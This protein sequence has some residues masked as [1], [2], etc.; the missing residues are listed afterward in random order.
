MSGRFEKSG[1]GTRENNMKPK[2]ISF[3]NIFIG[4]SAFFERTLS[5][6]DVRTFAL[7]SGDMNPLHLDE[8]YA[9]TTK[10]K[11]R[12]V[13]GMLL[14]SLCSALVGTYL[15]GKRCLYLRQTLS[16][17]KPVFVGDTVIIHGTVKTKSMSTKIV[18]I[19]ISITKNGEEVVEGMATVQMI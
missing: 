10:F 17:K 1:G 14:G 9:K 13:Y 16:F 2:D 7:L 11:R 5:D 3:E 6:E 8:E 18:E 19:L 4:D 15:P 12:L